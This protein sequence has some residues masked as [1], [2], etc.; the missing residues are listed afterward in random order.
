M[1]FQRIIQFIIDAKYGIIAFLL[2][3]M[4]LGFAQTI[5]LVKID[6]SLPAWFS[7]KDVE[8]QDYLEFQ[9][10]QGSDE[11]IIAMIPT[12]DALS[13][14]HITNL[15]ELHQ[16]TDSLPYVKTSFSIATAEYPIYSNKKIYYRNIYRI[17][18]KRER[19]LGL[20]EELPALE[21]QLISDDGNFSFFYVQLLPTNEIENVRNQITA[22]IQKIVI[23]T[24]GESHISGPPILNEAFNKTIYEESIFFSLVTVTI[25]LGLLFLLLPHWHYLPLASLSIMLPVSITLGVLTSLGYSLNLISMLI[26]SILMVYCVCDL[27]HVINI[28]HLHRKE[29][30]SESR[31]TQIKNALQS[32]FKPCFYT[33]LTTLIGYLALTVSP[34]SPFKT[35]G[36]FTAFGLMLAF[37]LV[38]VITAIGFTFLNEKSLQGKV[39][40]V[41][42]LAIIKKINY[43]TTAHN[44]K[45]LFIGC[46]VFAIG[47]GCLPFIEVNTNTLN[48]LKTGKVK[49]DL[50]LIE[51]TLAGSGRLQLNIYRTDTGS[52]LE[53]DALNK[54]KEF[55]EKLNQN[56]L[57]AHPISII[58]FQSFLEK[59]NSIFSRLQSIDFE[60]ML[61]ENQQ[62]S[63]GF[64]SLYADDFSYVSINI[65]IKEL[66]SKDLEY[67]LKT[68]K[69]EF[70]NSFDEK[71][72]RIK[73]YGYTAMYA[74]LNRYILQTQFQSVGI[75]FLLSFFI[76]FYFIKEFKTTILAFVPNLLP[77][78]AILITMVV[79]QIPL[80]SGNAMLAP[81][82]LGVAM[83]DTIHLMNK[84]KFYRD[85]N[86]SVTESI[87]RALNYTGSALFSTTFSLTIGFLIV[88][89]SGVRSVSIFGMLCAV[90]IVIALLADVLFLPALLKRFH[91]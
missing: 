76:L 84:F 61:K 60:K 63:N 23:S 14:K 16:R 41:N 52:A 20:L 51:K 72:Y 54:L 24:V 34:L 55:Q 27:V 12:D 85:S 49:D 90:A 21:K 22:E 30:I 77:L 89:L 8:Y 59:R 25:I 75:A 3:V 40:K 74:L 44:S 4:L 79:F 73:I 35:M 66:A 62:E 71:D 58:N 5:R 2:I 82:M 81:I 70:K 7:D 13:D 47:L 88:G 43:W 91:S 42:M 26:P 29:N 67:L 69:E 86:F 38:Y 64:F 53:P 10:Q 48:L 56:K 83:D 45:I 80:D 32:S 18:Q 87:D 65:N 28:F 6:N 19:T 31:N 1:N 68:I 37:C 57:L 39:K 50:Q 11:I 33:T 46:F 17:N 36:I 9:T 78:F 15:K